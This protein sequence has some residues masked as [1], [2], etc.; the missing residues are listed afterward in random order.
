M[1]GEEPGVKPHITTLAEEGFASVTVDR[2]VESFARHFMVALDAWQESGF[3][4]LARE[5]LPRLD[6]ENGLR[7]DIDEAGD[8]LLRRAGSDAVE[9]HSLTEALGAPSWLDPATGEL[10]A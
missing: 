4:A 9:R 3:A 10:R 7:R 5:Y 6:R 1:S 8:L 2:L